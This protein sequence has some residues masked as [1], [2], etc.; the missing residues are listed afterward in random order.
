MPG[1]GV[2]VNPHAKGNRSESSDRERRMSDI[3]GSDGSVRVT[4]TLDAVDQVAHEFV[5][6]NIDILAICGGDG[7]DHCTLTA[8]H[9]VYARVCVHFAL[10][11]LLDRS[12]TRFI[13]DSPPGK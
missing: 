12:P 8:F 6:R 2:V 1:I 11:T 7:S 5:D 4:A 10:R 3:L 9:R 13:V